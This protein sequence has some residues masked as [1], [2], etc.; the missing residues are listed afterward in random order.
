MNSGWGEIAL[1]EALQKPDIQFIAIEQEPDKLCVARHVA[2]G[3]AANITFFE[4][5]QS[6]ASQSGNQ[7]IQTIVLE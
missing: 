1:Y 6:E 4:T 3:R 2:E 7:E 5:Y